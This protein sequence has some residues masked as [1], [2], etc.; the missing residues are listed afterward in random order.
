MRVYFTVRICCK[1]GRYTES[2]GSPP[3]SDRGVIEEHIKYTLCVTF[4]IRKGV[5]KIDFSNILTGD[6]ID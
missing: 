1:S 6:L 5:Q 2:Y 4:L 3:T